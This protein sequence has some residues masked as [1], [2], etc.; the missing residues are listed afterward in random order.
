MEPRTAP[1]LEAEAFVVRDADRDAMRATSAQPP[2]T[3]VQF[4]LRTL[5]D[6]FPLEQDSVA[7]LLADNRPYLSHVVM[8]G[9]QVRAQLAAAPRRVPK[10]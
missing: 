2:A 8:Q 9:V 7:A 3:V 1:A 10:Y 4:L 6:S 5:Q